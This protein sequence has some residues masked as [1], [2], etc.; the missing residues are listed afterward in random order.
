MSGAAQGGHRPNGVRMPDLPSLLTAETVNLDQLLLDPNNPRF[1]ELGTGSEPVPESRFAEAR[2]QSKAFETMIEGNFEVAELRDTIKNLGFLP[3]DRLVVRRWR[4][5]GE[6][7]PLFVVV[8]G[9]RRVAALKS[10]VELHETARETF[11]DA[12]LTNFKTLE[13]L[14]L[15]DDAPEDSRWVLPGLR[16]VSGIKEWGPYQKA[17]AVAD[18]RRRGASPTNAAQSLGL[19]TRSANALWRAFLALEQMKQDEEFGDRARPQLY[20]YFEEALKQPD[21]KAW[22]GWNESD[23][24]FTAS[25][26]LREF[27]GWMFSTAE[28]DDDERSKKLPEA[29]SA[30]KLG[31][32]IN[33]PAAMARFRAPGGT[34]DEAVSRFEATHNVDWIGN[35]VGAESVLA[36]LGV[37][38]VKHFDSE[39]LE[40]LQRLA[41]RVRDRLDDHAR[42]NT[43]E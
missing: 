10:L 23:G 37:E 39:A 27:Y 13:V 43:S 31:K 12:Q 25:E 15:S 32:I 21:V 17:R 4:H 11:S 30:R 7:Q 9:N 38:T 35:V 24:K 26:N 18:L 33:D 16:H 1:A 8:E 5:H 42:L 6:G 41:D 34:L 19:P 36:S 29:K 2:V 14:V 3:M 40:A 20:S 22:L 28:D